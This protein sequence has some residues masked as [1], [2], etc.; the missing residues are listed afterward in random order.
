MTNTSNS[1][2]S[3][4]ASRTRAAGEDH[5]REGGPSSQTAP[6]PPAAETAAPWTASPGESDPAGR[7]RDDEI[8]HSAAL[9]FA[10]YGYH[11]ASLRD[12]AAHADISHPGM[13]HHFENKEDLLNAVIDR[14]ETHAQVALDRV[15]ELANEPDALRNA[16]LEL[17]HPASRTIQLLA[18]LC[19]DAV[20][21]DHPGRFRMSRLRRVHEHVLERCFEQLRDSAQLRSGIDPSFA[22][23]ATMDLILGHAI[24]EKTIRVMQTEPHGDSPREDISRM[25]QAF[26]APPSEG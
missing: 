1:P 14:L 17:W 19:T 23:R 16:L 8:L 22:G 20:S 12:I 2:A 21:D 5:A 13:L 26:L 11:G 15:D 6:L 3:A 7:T 18:M 24:R 4:G 9:L 25:L 10:D